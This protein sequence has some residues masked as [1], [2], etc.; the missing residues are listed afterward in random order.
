VN[1]SIFAQRQGYYLA[2]VVPKYTSQSFAINRISASLGSELQNGQTNVL[3]SGLAHAYR[4]RSHMVRTIRHC[5]L[6]E[7]RGHKLEVLQKTSFRKVLGPYRAVGSRI[8]VKG[9]D[10][11]PIPNV[12]TAWIANATNRALT[13]NAV[14]TLKIAYAFTRHQYF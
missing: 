14:A 8:L 5:N 2:K 3:L 10:I 7:I 6:K 13:S 9:A 1:Q 11:S 12:L 4:Q